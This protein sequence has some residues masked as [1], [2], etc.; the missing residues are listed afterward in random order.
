M[1]TRQ[2]ILIVSD[3]SDMQMYLASLL[4]ANDLEPLVARTEDEGVRA[5]G[6]KRLRCVVLD[7][8]MQGEAAFSLYRRLKCHH[9]LRQLPVMM[10]SP[11]DPETCLRYQKL[12]QYEP[13]REI[14]EPEACMERPPE[15]EDFICQVC[16]WTSAS[17]PEPE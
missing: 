14:P 9:Q 7:M 13:G 1:E 10:L 2:R 12:R 4:H 15:A 5:A 17:G 16:R 11:I 6:M 3:D 8:M